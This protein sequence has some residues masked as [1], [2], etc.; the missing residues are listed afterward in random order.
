M[1]F[2][3]HL[4]PRGVFDPGEA[5]LWQRQIDVWCKGGGQRDVELRVQSNEF[6]LSKDEAAS[7]ERRCLQLKLRRTAVW[8]PT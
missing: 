4:E 5:A 6:P 1:G 3:G 8:P 2:T 7:G